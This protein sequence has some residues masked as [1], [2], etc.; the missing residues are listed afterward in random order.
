MKAIAVLLALLSFVAVHDLE[1][2]TNAGKSMTLQPVPI[3][4][5]IR[6]SPVVPA[7]SPITGQGWALITGSGHKPVNLVSV[8]PVLPTD[9]VITVRFGRTFTYV[10]SIVVG[11]DETLSENY[12]AG[13][14]VGLDHF[15][16]K[17][18]D[19]VTNLPVLPYDLI[20][21]YG[22]F[23]ISGTMWETV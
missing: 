5:A 11:T 1:S 8:D 16:I 6:N 23:W 19:C 4:G 21:Q 12:R 10:G 22:N 13:S 7:T 15:Y 14:S 20:S 2:H 17:F 3:A 18:Y 9:T